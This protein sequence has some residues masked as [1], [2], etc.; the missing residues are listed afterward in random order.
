[1]DFTGSLFEQVSNAVGFVFLDRL[2]VGYLS[3][4][5]GSFSQPFY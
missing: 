4:D 5:F 2:A 1:L 3:A